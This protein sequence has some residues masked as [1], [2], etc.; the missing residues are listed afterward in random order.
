MNNRQFM[1]KIWEIKLIGSMESFKRFYRKPTL[2]LKVENFL[3][4]AYLRCKIET[5]FPYRLNLS[6]S[7]KIY[8]RPK[9]KVE[10]KRKISNTESTFNP[11]FVIF[12][13]VI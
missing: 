3:F 5:K 12:Y 7:F 11:I 13:F 10:S 4:S 6:Y 8:K 1:L 9:I 2:K